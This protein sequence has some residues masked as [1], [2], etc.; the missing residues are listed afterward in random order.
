MATISTHN[1][2]SV[3]RGHNIRDE[4]CIAKDGHIDLHRPHEIWVDEAPRSAYKRIFG[5]SVEEYNA[6]QT[7]EDRKIKDYYRQI[8]D[9]KKK[10]P[11]YEMIIGIYPEA[12]ET[13]PD[14]VGKEIMS[15][16]VE[17]WQERNPNL[18]M[19][20]AYYHA[21][22]QGKA[23]HV[24]IDYIPIAHGYKNGLA[25]QNGLVKALGEMGFEKKGKLTAQIQWEKRE[26]E[27]LEKLCNARNI[28]VKHPQEGKGVKHLHTELYKANKDVERAKTE[29]KV[30]KEQLDIVKE[31]TNHVRTR[32]NE[33][34]AEVKE[35][36]QEISQLKDEKKEL[37]EALDSL[38]QNQTQLQ[39]ISEIKQLLKAQ[40]EKKI[41]LLQQQYDQMLNN[42]PKEKIIER[43]VEIPKYI[44]IPVEKPVEVE[45]VVEI[46]KC[47]EV[48]LDY[49][50]CFKSALNAFE[51]QSEWLI[52]QGLG[53][54]SYYALSE[55]DDY[56]RALKTIYPRN[57]ANVKPLVPEGAEI[58]KN[59]H[60]IH[61][62]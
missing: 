29:T 52:R 34:S 7:R 23:P 42:P 21:D 62:R 33:L 28:S 25:I 15:E 9:D 22:E 60:H 11:V 14:K 48:N 54:T 27:Y 57:R 61:R 39:Q 51:A 17:N 20:G 8:V 45:K 50:N 53:T 16:F 59:Q 41:E 5:Q 55:N 6:I 58:L 2:S 43:V 40:L 32:K 44:E 31:R 19:I 47:I 49:K 18:E 4:K 10:H 1:G 35:L 24:H 30:Y 36:R 56:L 38:Q 3:A 12:G 46:K 37:Q 26:N 13:V